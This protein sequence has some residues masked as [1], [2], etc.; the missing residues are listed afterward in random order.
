MIDTL[1]FSLNAVFPIFILLI[2][3]MILGKLKL[4]P[5]EFYRQAE[6]F[7]FKISIP[8]MLFSDIVSADIGSLI[9]FKLIGFI[10]MSVLIAIGLAF[11]F[12]PLFV[13]DDG[14]RGAMIQGI[15]RSN[16]AI[17]GVPLMRSMFGDSGAA[18][19]ATIVPFAVTTF[20]IM[21]VIILTVYGPKEKKQDKKTI[22]LGILKNIAKNPLI[23][24]I[25]AAIPFALL[26]VDFPVYI[27]KTLSSISGLTLPL[28]MISLG[29]GFKLESLKGR[30]GC[31]L[32]T[33][34]LRLIVMP[35]LTVCVAIAIGYTGAKLGAVLA[36]FGGPV[37][38]AS[39]VMARNM[40]SDYEMSGQIL[41]LTTFGSAFTLFISIFLLKSVG[42]F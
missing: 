3:G 16:I 21:A 24:G 13:K 37:A 19:M 5:D 40:D 6:K 18:L 12:I 25:A 14:K 15:Y 30:I 9:D 26:K 4:F 7:A 17:I 34:V 27:D 8:V 42:L 35:A 10:L 2:L 31:A 28:A 22:A 41:V 29:S 11:V 20:N 23:I 36:V 38:V 32:I 39:Y 1:I 33:T